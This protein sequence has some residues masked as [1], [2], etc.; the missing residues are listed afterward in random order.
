MGFKLSAGLGLALLV[1]SGA[2]KLYY[3]KSQ[4]EIK[5]FHLQLEQSIQNQKTL[6]GTIK[7]QNEN[8]KQTVENHELMVAQVEKLTKENMVAQNEVTDIRKKFSRH[9]LDVLSIRKPKLIENVINRG[10]KSVLNDLKI[11][12]DETQFNEDINISDPVTG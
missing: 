2:F 1:L 5:A 12:T 6:E 10:T 3:D 11:I 8:L 9:S 7:Q 4:S